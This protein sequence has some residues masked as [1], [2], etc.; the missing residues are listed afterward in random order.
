MTLSYMTIAATWFTRFKWKQ[1]HNTIH[2]RFVET[3][4]NSPFNEQMTPRDVRAQTVLHI[5]L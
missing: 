2:Y 4:C 5:L 1:V 3:Y